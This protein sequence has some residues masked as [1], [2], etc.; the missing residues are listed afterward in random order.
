[1][2]LGAALR[3]WDATVL[4]GSELHQWQGHLTC[5]S[6]FGGFSSSYSLLSQDKTVFG[7]WRTPNLPHSIW[8][9]LMSCIFLS[10]FVLWKCS[11]SI[12]G[13]K[14]W[15]T[16][17]RSTRHIWRQKANLRAAFSMMLGV[18]THIGNEEALKPSQFC[19]CALSLLP[20]FNHGDTAGPQA[21]SSVSASFHFRTRC[22][23]YPW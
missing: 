10:V 2:A 4:E 5:F 3:P 11:C 20:C 17:G 22:L 19:G 23:L 7:L 8:V 6:S 18:G 15:L 16:K 21:P 13:I 9:A 1:M 12:G 14:G